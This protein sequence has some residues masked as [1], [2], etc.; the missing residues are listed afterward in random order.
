VLTLVIIAVRSLLQHNR[1]IDSCFAR[2]QN[3]VYSKDLLIS[4]GLLLLCLSLYLLSCTFVLVR[5]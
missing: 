1:E 3:T 5:I 4:L 2:V